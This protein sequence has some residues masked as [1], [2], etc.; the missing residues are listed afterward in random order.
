MADRM[1]IG[2]L[3]EAAVV[4]VETVRFY[5][6]SGLIAE[7]ARPSGGYRTYGMDD[8]RRLRFIKRAQSLGFTLDEVANLLT[9]EG[10]RSCAS[11]RGLAA[12]KLATVASKVKDLLAIQAALTTMIARCDQEQGD[13]RCPLILALSDD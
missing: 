11:T 6:R 8:V 9:L 4:S 5:Q 7:P 2:G 10:A 1:T 3:A 13:A 12:A